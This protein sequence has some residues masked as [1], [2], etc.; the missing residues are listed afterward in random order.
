M[1]IP[2]KYTLSTHPINTPYQHTLSSH[3]I[4]TPY[5]HTLSTHPINTPYQ[6]TNPS[7]LYFPGDF[8]YTLVQRIQLYDTTTGGTGGGGGASYGSHPHLTTKG[9]SS[10]SVTTVVPLSI[11]ST[12]SPTFPCSREDLNQAYATD[13]KFPAEEGQL[14]LRGFVYVLSDFTTRAVVTSGFLPGTST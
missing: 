12:L 5:Q 4:F 2:N 7:G 8:P 10:M 11:P 14:Q 6:H 13:R 1:N 3:P 9:K